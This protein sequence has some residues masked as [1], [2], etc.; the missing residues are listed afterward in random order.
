VLRSL[1]KNLALVA[2]S[3]LLALSALELAIRR[4][5]VPEPRYVESTGWWREHWLRGRPGPVPK[6]FVEIHPELGWVPAPNLRKLKLNGARINTN[7]VG[8]RGA[9]EYPLERSG[10][11]RIVAVG[12]SFT[13]GQCVNDDESFPGRLEQLLPGSEVLNLGVMG[14]GHDQALQRLRVQGLAYRPDVVL[15]GFHRMDMPRNRLSFRDYAKP[16]FVLEDGGRLALDNVPVPM[17]EEVLGSLQ[18]RLWNYVLVQWNRRQWERDNELELALTRAIVRQMAAD[19]AGAGARFAVVQ[20]PEEKDVA[21]ASPQP[22]PWL[23]ETCADA[24]VPYVS[25]VLRI[26][27]ALRGEDLEEH[28]DCHYSP[29]VYGLVAEEVAESLVRLGWLPAAPAADREGRSYFN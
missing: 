5:L 21:N 22:L 7:S 3:S 15:L 20:L 26:H 11:P 18:P 23:V 14:Y 29:R 6:K 28:F 19:A 12:D 17:P 8:M 25:P 2:V 1:L 13:F 9:R 27:E 10:A 4:G 16:R 24:G